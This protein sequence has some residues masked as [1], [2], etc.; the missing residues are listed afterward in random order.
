MS[1]TGFPSRTTGEAMKLIRTSLFDFV[2]T[3][4]WNFVA[5]E[6]ADMS[7]DTP[8]G[9]F[10]KILSSGQPTSSSAGKPR[11]CEAAWFVALMMWSGS[12][13]NAGSGSS[14]MPKR[15]SS[16][17]DVGFLAISSRSFGRCPLVGEAHA[18]REEGRR[19][20]ADVTFCADDQGR[21]RFD[22]VLLSELGVLG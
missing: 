20:C 1:A 5:P 4:I 7:S 11:S 19:R 13:T 12:V 9:G 22:V 16:S 3:L 2:L 21:Q 18:G 10:G 8:R 14:S 15:T 17:C 6:P